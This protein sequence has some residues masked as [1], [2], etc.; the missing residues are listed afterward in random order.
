MFFLFPSHDF[1]LLLLLLLVL[2]ETETHKPE[3]PTEESVK[4]LLY[5]FRIKK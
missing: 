5:L 3:K 1:R 4:V 2:K